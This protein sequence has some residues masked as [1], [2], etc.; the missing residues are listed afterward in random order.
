MVLD[1]VERPLAPP[2]PAWLGVA[3]VR[4]AGGAGAAAAAGGRPAQEVRQVVQD[5]LLARHPAL[6]MT[7]IAEALA[8][9]AG[10][11]D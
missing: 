3:T 4:R 11:P 6:P 7:M 10:A 1:L 5:V 9:A 2:A 8:A